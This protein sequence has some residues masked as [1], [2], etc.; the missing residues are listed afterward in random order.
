MM[1]MDVPPSGKFWLVPITA[2]AISGIMAT[3]PR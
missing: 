2:K 1:R 3:I